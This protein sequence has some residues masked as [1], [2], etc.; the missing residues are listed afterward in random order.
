M[1]IVK[2]NSRPT[3]KSWSRACRRFAKTRKWPRANRW[4]E[5][6]PLC[7]P[8]TKRRNSPTMPNG[9]ADDPMEAPAAKT[10]DKPA[11]KPD[12]KPA[13]SRQL[14]ARKDSHARAIFYRS[15]DFAG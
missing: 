2:R 12:D 4:K 11:A 3:K 10:D 9:A 6:F 7:P 5:T 1:R 13:T 8:R 14:T 15:T